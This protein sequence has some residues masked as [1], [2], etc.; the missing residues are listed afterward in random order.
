MSLSLGLHPSQT[1]SVPQVSTMPQQKIPHSSLPRV[2]IAET[3][4]GRPPSMPKQRQAPRLQATRQQHLKHTT[5]S[6][7]SPW[8][9]SS[10]PARLPLWA[11]PQQAPKR[12]HLRKTTH[13]SAHISIRHSERRAQTAMLAWTTLSLA[14]PTWTDSPSACG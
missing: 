5:T 14:M 12:Q 8:S 4:I 10:T 11:N 2:S 1:C 9:T 13:A 3:T 6:T 7:L